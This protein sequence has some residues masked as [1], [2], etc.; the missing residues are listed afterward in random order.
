MADQNLASL[1]QEECLHARRQLYFLVQKARNATV[2][3]CEYESRE[4]TRQDYR[5]GIVP[6]LM[7]RS[8]V[9][10][11]CYERNPSRA[12]LLALGWT[13]L[14]GLEIQY[15]CEYGEPST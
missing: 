9:T 2:R 7:L 11:R 12:F 5:W 13:R 4:T 8:K 6:V 15:I 3:A 10:Q 1:G 14:I